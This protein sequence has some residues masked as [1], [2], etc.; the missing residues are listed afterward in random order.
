MQTFR[1]S[2]D[3]RIYDRIKNT[4][5]QVSDSGTVEAYNSYEAG[6]IILRTLSNKYNNAIYTNYQLTRIK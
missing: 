2:V 4:K 1:Y 3:V 6:N 5:K